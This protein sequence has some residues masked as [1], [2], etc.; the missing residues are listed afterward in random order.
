MALSEGTRSQKH[1]GREAMAH[2]LPARLSGLIS[3]LFEKDKVNLEDF[4][5]HK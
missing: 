5:T 2:T 3:K 4:N 1:F